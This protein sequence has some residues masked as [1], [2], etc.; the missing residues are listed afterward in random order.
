MIHPVDLI[1]THFT[2]LYALVAQLSN[3]ARLKRYIHIEVA[4][5]M[6]PIHLLKVKLRELPFTAFIFKSRCN[7]FS[8]DGPYIIFLSCY[9][10]SPFSALWPWYEQ[11]SVSWPSY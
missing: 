8:S 2:S 5:S 7:P 6:G 1:S 9:Y 11:D 4:M 3:S 10:Y